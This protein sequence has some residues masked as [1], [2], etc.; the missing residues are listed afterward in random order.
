MFLYVLCVVFARLYVVKVLPYIRC[1]LCNG[2]RVSI[3]V[4]I[5]CRRFT[6][7]L[8]Q[9]PVYRHLLLCQGIAIVGGSP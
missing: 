2:Y 8:G 1:G 6:L 7:G 5:S 9:A 3:I 4:R